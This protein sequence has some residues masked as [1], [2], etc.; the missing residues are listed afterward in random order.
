VS[1]YSNPLFLFSSVSHTSLLFRSSGDGRVVTCCLLERLQ[2]ERDKE[3]DRTAESFARRLLISHE[4]LD[5]DPPG[6]FIFDE[7]PRMDNVGPFLRVKQWRS[8][9][10][11]WFEEDAVA[12]HALDVVNSKIASCKGRRGNHIRKYLAQGD[13]SGYSLHCPR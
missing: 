2:I 11:V 5:T 4:G 6:M 12:Q 9:L 1:T 10:D 13:E 8:R 7:A 3:E